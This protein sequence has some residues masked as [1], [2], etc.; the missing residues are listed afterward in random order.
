MP[1]AYQLENIAYSPSSL[2]STIFSLILDVFIAVII[3][4][5]ITR[6]Y[7]NGLVFNLLEGY[8]IILG[9]G[10]FFYLV[11]LSILG[12]YLSLFEGFVAAL[13]FALALLF[14]KRNKKENPRVRN[15]TT[16][17]SSIGMGIL[18]GAGIGN[19]LILYL[20]IA[21][22]AVYDYVAVFVLKF[23]IPLAKQAVNMNLAFMISSSDMEAIP[24]TEFTEKEKKE[25]NIFLKKNKHY[26]EHVREITK[27]GAIPTVSSIMLG[28]GDIMLPIAVAAGS[29][30]ATANIFL[31][32]LL[33]IFSGLGVITTMLILRKYKVGLPAIPPLFSFISIAFAIFFILEQPSELFYILLF[34]IASIASMV[35]LIFTLRRIIKLQKR[36]IK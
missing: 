1:Y 8:I 29:Y 10:T 9:S 32:V 3:F 25:F 34:L 35:A 2:I 21:V 19:L 5:L 23:M 33:V 36:L 6:R 11:I 20:L 22:F 18:I 4:M 31:S 16:M 30:A 14:I 13:I 26:A 7:K 15:I 27:T 12:V 28:N 17:L 24:K